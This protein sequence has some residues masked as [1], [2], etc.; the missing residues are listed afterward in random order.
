MSLLIAALAALALLTSPPTTSTQPAG[1][2][3]VL[4]A[5]Q[6]PIVYDAVLPIG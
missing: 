3:I 6:A 1:T 4:P 5:G 2:N